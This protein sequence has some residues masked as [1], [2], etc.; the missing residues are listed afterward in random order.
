MRNKV[1]EEIIKTEEDYV[2]Q[3]KTIRDEFMEDTELKLTFTRRDFNGT[4]R[5]ITP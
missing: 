4:I 2:K 1:I 3:L 5:L